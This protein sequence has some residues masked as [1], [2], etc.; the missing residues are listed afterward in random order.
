M[1]AVD[2]LEYRIRNKAEKNLKDKMGQ[3]AIAFKTVLSIYHNNLMIEV[4]TNEGT[5]LSI[6]TKPLVEAIVKMAFNREKDGVGNKAIKT[7]ITKVDT[8][9][10]DLDELRDNVENTDD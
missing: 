5:T 9:Q 10:A 3:A 2:S 4:D 7:F 1:S 8:L 6:N